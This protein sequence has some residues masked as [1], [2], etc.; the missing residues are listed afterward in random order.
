MVSLF[1]WLRRGFDERAVG[2]ANHVAKRCA[3]GDHGINGIFLLNAEIDEHGFS[4]FTRRTDDGKHFG[5]LGDALAADAEGV[6]QSGKIRS[7][8]WSGDVALVV[9]KFLP[10]ANHA[11]EA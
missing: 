8:Q 3:G 11:E 4:R 9:K 10:L 7:D 1:L 2:A 6:G 5:A